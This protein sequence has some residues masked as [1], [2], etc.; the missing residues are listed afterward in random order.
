MPLEE[1]QVGT[2]NP[3]KLVYRFHRNRHFLRWRFIPFIY[4]L[5]PRPAPLDWRFAT[6]PP[7][8][9]QRRVAHGPQMPALAP[10]P[11]PLYTLYRADTKYRAGQSLG[12]AGQW[13]GNVGT[14]IQFFLPLKTAKHPHSTH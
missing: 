14:S 7:G 10:P 8:S 5:V 3:S 2:I 12:R 4:N 11:L 13:T 9:L 6:C 1:R